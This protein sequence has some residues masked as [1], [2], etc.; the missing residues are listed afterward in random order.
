MSR[1][2]EII[3]LRDPVQPVA[4]SGLRAHQSQGAELDYFA[5]VPRTATTDSPLLVTVHG[6][7]RM[8]L[9]HAVRFS[10]LAEKHGFIVVAPMFSKARVPRYQRL[11][12]G[13]Q[14]DCPITAFE[15]TVDHVQ[16]ATGLT[17]APLR[18]FG[19]SGG[20]QFAMRYTLTGSLPVGRL[21]LAA[22]GW[23]TMPDTQ[24][25][26][27]YGLGDSPAL[28]GRAAD[29]TRLLSIPVLLTV[30]AEDTRRD[31]SLNRDAIVESSQGKTRLQRA[32]RWYDAMTAAV[33]ARG[34]PQTMQFKLL[35]GAGHDFNDNMQTF[36][37]G[38]VV[39]AWLIN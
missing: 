25:P 24:Q 20:A 37:L 15:L 31:K 33:K 10:A 13:P 35:E 6:I 39:T 18:L 7:E 30:G 12:R 9:Q 2:A 32:H 19:Y 14:G 1:S 28:E 17:P 34:L 22:P 29:L 16:R 5:Y 36:G 3:P 26:F 38:E 21:A 11:E 4:L 23:F 27:P 8:A